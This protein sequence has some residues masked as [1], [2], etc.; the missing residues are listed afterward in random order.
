MAASRE[1]GLAPRVDWYDL[2][3]D[4]YPVTG[5]WCSTLS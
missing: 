3:D 5:V 4:F 2:V 1:V